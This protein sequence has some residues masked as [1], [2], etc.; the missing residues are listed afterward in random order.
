MEIN[1]TSRALV[2]G[3]GG[4]I[5]SHLVNALL[6]QGRRVR[7]LELPH[8]EPAKPIPQ[9]PSLE[10]VEGNFQNAG[11][12]RQALHDVGTVFH[13]V[14]TTQPLS[15][16]ED[17]AFD[18]QSNLVAAVGLLEQ[19][20]TLPEI[21]LIFISSGGTV[22]GTPQQ[23][24]IPETH[25]NEPQ[26][27]YGIVKL[28]IEKYLALYRL[29]HGI[30]Y[31]VLRFANPYGPGQESNRTQGVIGA[32]LSRALQEQPLEIWGDG[33]VVRD[34][35]Y[36]GDAIAA[37]LLAE[38]YQG[39]ERIFNIGSGR[40]YSLLE[41]I[42]AIERVCEKNV[43]IHFSAGRKVDVAVSV[44]DIQRAKNEL[45]WQPVT[46]LDQ[47]LHATLNWIRPLC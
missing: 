18:I 44:L 27:S 5:G 11:D 22:Y 6:L 38:R 20:R 14:S 28:S 8:R 33:S 29:M 7:V 31:R 26:C 46:T 12:I 2:I 47:G 32:F 36:I 34:Y 21:S 16:N 24:P 42:D 9:H 40:G 15:S 1:H 39:E 45:G 43:N 30:N 17:P 37:L 25:P 10:W 23:T 4:F 35:V 19:L 41:I 13:L 3:G